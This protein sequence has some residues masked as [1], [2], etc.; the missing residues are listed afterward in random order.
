MPNK[1][2]GLIGKSLGHSFSK[3]YFNTKFEKESIDAEYRNFE[4]ATIDELSGLINEHQR[5]VGLNVTIPY[6]EAVMEILD[7]VDPISQEVRAVNTIRIDR[8]KLTGYNTDVF[9][10]QQLIKPFFKGNHER[11][12]ILGTGGASK[13]VVYALEQIGVECRFVSRNPVASQMSYSEINEHVLRHHQLIVNTTPLGMF[14]NVDACPDIPY[15]M[16]SGQ[17]LLVD[18]IYNPETTLFMKKGLEKGTVAINGL[19]MLHQQAEQAWSI[20]NRKSPPR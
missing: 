6:K 9:G 16:L 2:F 20:W 12:L 4:I 13:A 18:L 19:T 3:N 7:E 10:F 14:P 17:H 5:L 1:L 15:E 11:A 8:G